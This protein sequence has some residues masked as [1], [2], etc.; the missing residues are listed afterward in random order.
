MMV[1]NGHPGGVP[2][3]GFTPPTGTPNGVEILN[4]TQLRHRVSARWLSAPRRPEFHHLLTLTS[5]TLHQSVDFTDYTLTPG[6]WLWVRPGQVQRWGDVAAAE[7]TLVLFEPLFLDATGMTA[8]P[9]SEVVI[10]PSRASP[11]PWIRALTGYV[12]RGSGRS[13]SRP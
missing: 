6:M 10:T 12:V 1:K 13:G 11:H 4:L 8:D 2:A 3:I 7:G 9:H 5:G